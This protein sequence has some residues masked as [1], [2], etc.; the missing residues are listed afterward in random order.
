MKAKTKTRK[1]VKK[2]ILKK[3][4]KAVKKSAAK[5]SAPIK[6]EVKQDFSEDLQPIAEAAEP[7]KLDNYD[8]EDIKQEE[9]V[10]EVVEVITPVEDLIA[11]GEE[12]EKQYILKTKNKTGERVLVI[13]AISICV[14]VVAVFWWR[15]TWGKIS[16]PGAWTDPG[17]EKVTNELSQAKDKM[18]DQIN[19]AKESISQITQVQNE[20]ADMAIDQFNKVL[21]NQ[22]D[23]VK[24]NDYTD[25]TTVK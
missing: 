15:T 16:A 7:L 22:V 12:E 23:Y 10:D 5:F 24:I 19:Q 21:I 11:D 18:A 13:F 6:I 14:L 8:Y 2:K 25:Y 20:K 3:V 1:K 17:L 4:K 9:P